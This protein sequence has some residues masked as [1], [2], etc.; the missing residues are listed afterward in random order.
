MIRLYDIGR[1]EKTK[2]PYLIERRKFKKDVNIKDTMAFITF[3][4]KDL[5]LSKY[6][7]EHF[8]LITTDYYDDIIGVFLMSIGDFRGCEVYTRTIATAILLSGGRK[9]AVMH[10]HPDGALQFSESDNSTINVMKGISILLSTEFMNSYI[11]TSG[12]FIT[13]TM[14]SPL[15][16]SEMEE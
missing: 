5:E 6:D 16:Y 15:F 14:D 2:Q 9:F 8:Y 10:N 12:G 3:V 1:N 7:N 13:D 11:F 4:K